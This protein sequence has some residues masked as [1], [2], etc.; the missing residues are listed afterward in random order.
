MARGLGSIYRPKYRDKTT[1]QQKTSATWWIKYYFRGQAKRESS[2]SAKRGDAARLLSQRLAEVGQGRLAGPDAAKTTFE[3]LAEMLLNDYRIN[4]HRSLS[5]IEDSVNHLRAFF[6]KYRAVDITSDRIV[7]YMAKRQANPAANATI[8][9]EL[10]ALKSAKVAKPPYIE[11]L[12]ENNVRKGFFEASE[13]EA[14]RD[15]LPG[16]LNPV[17]SVAYITGWRVSSEILTRQWPHV[18]FRAGW[19]RLEPGES[20]NKDGRVFPFTNDLRAVLEEQ[21]RKTEAWQKLHK[22]IVP[23]VFHREGKPIKYFRRSWLTA[24]R[25]AGVRGRIPHDFRRTAARN[26]DRAGVPRSAAMAMVGHKTQS[27]YSRYAIADEK[28]LKESAEKLSQFEHGQSTGKV[29]VVE[30]NGK[31]GK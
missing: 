16:H 25:L 11:M 7:A 6:G 23:W 21:R 18:D 2:G 27:I 17:A 20:K 22:T 14:I 29:K 30:L 10:S 12:Q 8:N 24:C 19:L 1:G 5:R 28:M 26:L 13:F 9:R 3:E 4:G 31:T 15:N